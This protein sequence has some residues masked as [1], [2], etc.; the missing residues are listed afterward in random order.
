MAVTVTSSITAAFPVNGSSVMTFT[1][2]TA[3]LGTVSA[4]TLQIYNDLGALLTTINMGSLLVAVYSITADGYFTFVETITDNTGT[5]TG[6]F[7]FTATAFYDYTFANTIAQLGC[8]CACGSE[9]LTT[10]DIAEQFRTASI[11][12][13][14]INAGVTSQNNITMANAVLSGT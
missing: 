10:N 8:S 11:I 4:R 3:G 13:G 9:Q 12:F 5:Y 14:S 2:S 7:G 1:D 6:T